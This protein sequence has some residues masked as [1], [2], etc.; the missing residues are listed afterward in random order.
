V[1]K[2]KDIEDYER[3]GNLVLKINKVLAIAGPLLTGIAAVGSAFVGNGSWAAIVAVA[4]GALG[5]AV[6]AFE[7]GGQ[8]GMVFEMYRNCGG[9][10]R[11]LQESIETTLGERDLEKRENGELFEMNV[12][13]KLGRSL[14]QLK[15]LARKSASARMD[16]SAV[17]EF[18]SKLF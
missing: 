5:S 3:L 2:R 10:F 7:H 13:L 16:R 14:S 12:A 18:A 11:L 15:Q 17:D 6:N 8:I 1:V 9:F 4:A